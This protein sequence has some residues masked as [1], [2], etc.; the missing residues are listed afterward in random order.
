MYHLIDRNIRHRKTWRALVTAQNEQYISATRWVVT[1]F[2]NTI[3]CDRANE[4]GITYYTTAVMSMLL[5]PI[6]C[7]AVWSAEPLTTVT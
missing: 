6:V 3:L 1:T 5:W 4:I 7:I 2:S